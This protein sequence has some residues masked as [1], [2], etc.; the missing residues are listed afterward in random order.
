M[1]NPEVTPHAIEPV[2]Q[3]AARV[4]GLAYLL[5]FAAVVF[6]QFGIHGRLFVEGN[7]AETARNI[8][9][10]QHLFRLGIACD[11]AYC[12]GVVAVLSALYVIFR[13]VN[14]QLALVATF[15]RLTYA[16]MWVL[17][18]LNLFDA[19]RFVNGADALRVL[20]AEPLQAWARLNLGARFD[21][22]YVGLLFYGLASTVSGHLWYRSGYIPKALAAWGFIS[23][24]FCAVCTFAFILFPNIAD[25]VNLWWFDTPIG[26]FDLA[27]SLWLLFKGL[28]TPLPH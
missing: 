17:M 7:A 14:W 13:P 15:G 1:V 10:H 12:V 3:A 5:A 9:A 23:A 8:L 2:Q 19:L 18:T 28:R 25:V 21:Q 24:L 6:A 11:L 4:A 20:D 27:V 16:L 22:Y 26:L